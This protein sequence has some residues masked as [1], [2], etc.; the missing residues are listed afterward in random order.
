L[1]LLL[2]LLLLLPLA[3]LQQNCHSWQ[4]Q[5]AL[6]LMLWLLWL[7]CHSCAYAGL[8]QLQQQ[9]QGWYQAPEAS[10]A[11]AH[12]TWT[13]CHQHCVPWKPPTGT[14][15]P[16]PAAAA[17]AAPAAAAGAAVGRLVLWGLLAG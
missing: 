2:L 9:L 12:H 11:Q 3:W 10:W 14:R 4:R 17:A 8:Q 7:L 1:L 6:M 5:L 15:Q 16:P 13:A